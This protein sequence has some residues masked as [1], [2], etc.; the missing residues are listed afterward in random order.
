[1]KKKEYIAPAMSCREMEPQQMMT[2]SN[3]LRANG[4]VKDGEGNTQKDGSFPY[5]TGEEGE[6]S[7]AK[8]GFNPWTEW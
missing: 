4:E 6:N 7:D 2:D 8:W 1:M 3:T 5:G